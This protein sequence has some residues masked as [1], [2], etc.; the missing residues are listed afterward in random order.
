MRKLLFII[1]VLWAVDLFAFN[2]RYSVAMWQEVKLQGQEFS[3]NVERWLRSS[4]L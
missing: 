4:K 1:G 3:Y 2:S